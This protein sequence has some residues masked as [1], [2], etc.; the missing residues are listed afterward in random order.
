[1]WAMLSSM[2]WKIT[3]GTLSCALGAEGMARL[4]GNES[5]EESVEEPGGAQAAAE[6][7]SILES[8][9]ASA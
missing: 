3:A 8:P 5:V 9:R 1:M 7:L 2:A 6:T 4:F